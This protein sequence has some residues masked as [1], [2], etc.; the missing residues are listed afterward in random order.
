M[1]K[2][3]KS[4]NDRDS[5]KFIFELSWLVLLVFGVGPKLR[6]KYLFLFLFFPLI[7]FIISG[8]TSKSNK[9]N[10]IL[11]VFHKRYSMLK[12]KFSRDQ[13]E[14]RPLCYN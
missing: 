12:R 6:R 2:I 9:S 3:K 13:I 5:W 10:D 7:F 1:I 11:R 14:K 8:K 4:R